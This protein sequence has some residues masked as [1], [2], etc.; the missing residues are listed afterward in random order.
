MTFLVNILKTKNYDGTKTLFSFFK[1]AVVNQTAY[2]TRVT[3]DGTYMRNGCATSK[4]GAY[5]NTV[6]VCNPSA[7]SEEPCHPS[8][9]KSIA[10]HRMHIL[11]LCITAILIKMREDLLEGK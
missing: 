9:A 5:T 4:K 3:D 11:F 2:C 1:N 10:A 6:C 8:G 7:D